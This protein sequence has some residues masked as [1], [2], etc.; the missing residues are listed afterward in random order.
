LAAVLLTLPGPAQAQLNYTTNN[1][2]ITIR[3][4][5]PSSPGLVT[6]PDTINGLP[7][8]RIG[9]GAFADCTSL[10]RIT[11]PDGVTSIGAFAF[12]GCT[13]LASVIIPNSVTSIGSQAFEDC[14]SLTSITIPDSVTSIGS[15][16]FYGCTR[17]TSVMIPVSVTSIGDGAFSGCTR[18]TTIQVDPLNPA[19]CSVDDVLFNQGQTL[20]IAFPGAKPGAYVIPNTVT[21]IADRA[22]WA[23][24]SLTSIA[25][26]SSVTSSGYAALSS[27]PRLTAIQVDPLNPSYSSV[28]GVLLNKSQTLLIACP[29]AKSGAYV[30]SDNVTSIG[31]RAFSGCASLTRI[32]IPNSV[33]SIRFGAFADCTSLTRITVPDSVTRIDEGA[34]WGCTSLTTVTIP[35]SVS[36]I[37]EGAFDDCT[38]L[39]SITIPNS[40]TSIGWGA[41]SGCTGLR[42]TYFQGNAPGEG[43]HYQL[44]EGADNVTV[45]YLPGTT[46]W[47]PTFAGRPT[48]LWANPVI[49][50]GTPGNQDTAF[51]FRVS[52]APNTTLVV[53]TCSDLATPTWAALA[54]NT[55]ISGSW[56]FI[57]PDSANHPSRFYRVRSP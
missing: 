6:I 38:S 33:T 5:C 4:G 40:V 39:T 48:A 1:G 50:P 31:D 8:T 14:T 23:C 35:D 12:L 15:R 51:G 32:T 37:D 24:T 3:G 27:C 18:L 57:D 30:I 9:E 19:H 43:E 42:G 56:D 36:R 41:F 16:A 52:W 34:F 45:F 44:F 10:T 11:I 49:M 13:R 26:P 20:L 2:T 17:L 7:V 55:P 29:G 46:G 54:T 47:Q 22:F 53:E 28:D 21:N 25:I